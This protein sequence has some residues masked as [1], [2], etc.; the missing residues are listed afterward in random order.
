[1]PE[2]PSVVVVSLA[3]SAWLV[4]GCRETR[5]WDD[6][7]WRPSAPPQRVVLGSVLAAESLLDVLPRERIAGVH[8]FAADPR[9]SLVAAA[10]DAL[11]LVGAEPERL[12]AVEP[13]LV[14]VDAF[15]RPETLALLDAAGVPVVRACDPHGFGDVEANL[16][17]LGRATHLDSEVEGIVQS[18]RRELEAIEQAG[19]QLAGWRLLGLDGALHSYGR[20]SL[21]DAIA[22]AAGARNVASERG[23][24]E[25]LKLDV[26][27]VLAW[28]PDAIV[29]AAQPGE[30]DEVPEWL[31]QYPGLELLPCVQRR[32]LVKVPAPLLTTTSHRLVEAARFVQRQ[33]LAWGRP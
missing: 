27:V 17:L 3:C 13:D 1:M 8:A 25:F 20:G 26:E 6:P 23:V 11:P 15:T 19:G 29:I 5:P 22:S 21:F 30:A 24:G 18:M 12:L 16:R 10:A 14:L 4:G 31:R 7:A 2:R 32:R 28:S 33:L 9:Y